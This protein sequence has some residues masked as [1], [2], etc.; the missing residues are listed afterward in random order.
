[1]SENKKFSLGGFPPIYEIVTSI[2]NKGFTSA[3]T[4]I[5][6]IQSILARKNMRPVV[7]MPRNKTN[8]NAEMQLNRLPSISKFNE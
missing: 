8:K 3:P 6:S 2:K 4:S 1:M 7:D 5:L